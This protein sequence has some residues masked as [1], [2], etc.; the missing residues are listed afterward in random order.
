MVKA[1][2]FV[3]GLAYRPVFFCFFFAVAAAAAQSGGSKP[4]VRFEDAAGMVI[5]I[6]VVIVVLVYNHKNSGSK[7]ADTAPDHS[8]AVFGQPHRLLSNREKGIL[9]EF[10]TYL[11][12]IA[13]TH[14]IHES[15]EAYERCVDKYVNKRLTPDKPLRGIKKEDKRLRGLR[16]KLGRDAHSNASGGLVFSTRNIAAP[17][18]ISIFTA[19]TG[20]MLVR[21]AKIIYTCEFYFTVHVAADFRGT[22]K[23]LPGSDVVIT[24]ERSGGEI[25]KAVVSA[26]GV[27]SLGR[28][29]RLAHSTHLLHGLKRRYARLEMNCL[30]K[31]QIWESANGTKH[32]KSAVSTRTSYT[33]NISGGGLCFFAELPLPAG[34]VLLLTLML[35][36]DLLSDIKAKILMTVSIPP[37]GKIGPRYRHHVEFVGLDSHKREQ[38]INFVSE[39][40]RK[41]D[42]IA[43][44]LKG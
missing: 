44:I 37:I 16:H 23:T 28:E 36:N 3:R 21:G 42:R 11:P 24:F 32:K 35:Q 17:Q 26:M 39:K 38:I 20:I 9:D 34:D 15:S 27:D 6:F 5:L 10:S 29:L 31:Y 33:A 41:K 8:Q 14:Q 18:D 25:Y 12:D 43:N 22:A 4:G 7:S 2:M 1:C 19:D 40:L 13:E 30:L